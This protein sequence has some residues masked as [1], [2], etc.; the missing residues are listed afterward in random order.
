[1]IR[2]VP[3]RQD[4]DVTNYIPVV[5]TNMILAAD[6]KGRPCVYLI[7]LVGK[8]GQNTRIGISIEQM[9]QLK[10]SIEDVLVK[11]PDLRT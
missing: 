4:E 1:M 10:E 8:Q 3:E 2:E 6:D 11:F 5:I 9:N 7:E